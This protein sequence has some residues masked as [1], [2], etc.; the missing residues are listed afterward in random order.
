M[1]RV[2]VTASPELRAARIAQASSVDIDRARKAVAQSD[3]DRQD[4]LRRFYNV[5]EELSTHY[6]LTVSTDALSVGDA[7]HLVM[8]AARL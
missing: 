1:L 8:A 2:L 5:R 7:A 3:R 6:D 4:F